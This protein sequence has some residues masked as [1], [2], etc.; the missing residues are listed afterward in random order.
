M[1]WKI[2]KVIYPILGVMGLYALFAVYQVHMSTELEDISKQLRVQRSQLEAQWKPI[3]EAQERIAK[4]EEDHKSLAQFNENSHSILQLL[5]LLSEKTPDDTW[6]NFLSL[7]KGKL[8]L[9]GM[10]KSAVDYLSKLSQIEGFE[11]VKFASPV[12]RNTKTDEERIVIDIRLDSGKLRATLE[13]VK[14]G[15]NVRETEDSDNETVSR[16]KPLPS[17]YSSTMDVKG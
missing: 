6:L 3:E 11:E 13:Q 17:E 4:L 2:P 16:K 15:E 8:T 1:P 9:R 5:D 10:S 7:K 12:S 14:E